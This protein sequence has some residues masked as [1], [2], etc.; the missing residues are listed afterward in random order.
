M[1]VIVNFNTIFF[2][3]KILKIFISNFLN[4][5]KIHFEVESTFKLIPAITVLLYCILNYHSNIVLFRIITSCQTEIGIFI[6]S[7]R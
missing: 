3:D 2:Q 5:I 6:F 4:V 7:F 1:Y